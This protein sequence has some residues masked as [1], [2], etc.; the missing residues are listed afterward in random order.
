MVFFRKS[1]CAE[2]ICDNHKII[3]THIIIQVSKCSFSHAIICSSQSAAGNQIKLLLPLVSFLLLFFLLLP[4]KFVM[5]DDRSSDRH[6]TLM[7]R[8]KSAGQPWENQWSIS[9]QQP[10]VGCNIYVGRATICSQRSKGSQGNQTTYFL[11]REIYFIF[12]M[13]ASYYNM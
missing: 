10:V 1:I 8:P 9:G 5:Y 4:G 6:L 3:F 11:L 7:G 13:S 2:V 12:S